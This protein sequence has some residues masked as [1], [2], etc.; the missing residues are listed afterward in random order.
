MIQ[1][2]WKDYFSFSKKEIKG[3]IVLGF[4]LLGSILLSHLFSSKSISSLV[5]KQDRKIRIIVFDPNTIDSVQA[6]DLGI[7]E[8]QVRTLLR[9]RAKGGFFRE[10]E[11]FS[12]LYGLTTEMYNRLSPYIKITPREKPYYTRFSNDHSYPYPNKPGKLNWTIDINTALEPEWERKTNLPLDIIRRVLAYKKYLGAFTKPSQLS[13]VY[14]MSDSMYQ[15][16]RPHIVIDF[17]KAPSMNMNTMR[18]NEWKNLG[19]FTDQQIWAILKLKKE[20]GGR[21]GW[22]SLIEA[23][24]LTEGEA[25][26]LKKKLRLND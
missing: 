15:W 19:M 18:F 21:I 14:G 9:Y 16:I 24:D 13:K 20:N 22:R 23:T 7:P 6:L 8:K 1:S 4:I 10:K 3:I 25:S 5:A 12:K 11:D 2:N 26:V 17:D